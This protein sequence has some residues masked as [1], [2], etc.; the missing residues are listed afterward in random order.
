MGLTQSQITRFENVVNNIYKLVRDNTQA[1]EAIANTTGFSNDRIA[2]ELQPGNGPTVSILPSGSGA[3]GGRGGIVIDPSMVKN[4]ASID[5]A[6]KAQLSEQTLGMA[7]TI[8]HEYGHYGDQVTNHGNNSGQYETRSYENN[9]GGE[10]TTRLQYSEIFGGNNIDLG[11]QR[12]KTT[13]TGHRGTDIEA[14]G[15]GVQFSVDR[16]GKLTREPSK[17]SITIKPDAATVPTSLPENAQGENIL[18]T[19]NVQ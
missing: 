7:L 13:L 14:V 16:N 2:S 6:D 5:G 4:L 8:L 19:L 15:F 17:L 10:T 1:M 11:A 18:K 9:S 3:L 12:W